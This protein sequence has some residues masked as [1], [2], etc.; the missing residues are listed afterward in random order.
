MFVFELMNRKRKERYYD[1][2]V[3]VKKNHLKIILR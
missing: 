2:K 1:V 3:D